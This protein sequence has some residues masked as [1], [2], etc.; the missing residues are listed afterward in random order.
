M[1][2]A[3]EVCIALNVIHKDFPKPLTRH[4]TGGRSNGRRS[5]RRRSTKRSGERQELREQDGTESQPKPRRC[6]TIRR[7]KQPDHLGIG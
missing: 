2:L 5:T 7:A 3:L 6:G 1:L 4:P